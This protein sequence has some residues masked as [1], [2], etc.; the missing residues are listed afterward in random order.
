MAGKRSEALKLLH[1]IETKTSPWEVAG[2]YARLGD[3]D[4]AFEWLEKAYLQRD[5]QLGRL[6]VW[7]VVDNLRS[8]PRYADL[9]RRI[10]LPP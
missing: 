10:G 1:E 3:K 9:L 2:I 6:K 4:K 5:F 8:D 7:P